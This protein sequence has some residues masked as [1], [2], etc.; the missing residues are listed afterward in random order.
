MG[1][2]LAMRSEYRLQ[3]W[4][5]IIDE[6]SKS[7]MTKKDFCASRGISDKTYYYWLRKLRESASESLAP[8]LVEV[9]LASS[10]KSGCINMRFCGAEFEINNETPSDLLLTTLRVLKQL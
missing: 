5:M 9:K 10:S 3:Q 1:N 4:A 8:Q 2:A 7:G 6:C